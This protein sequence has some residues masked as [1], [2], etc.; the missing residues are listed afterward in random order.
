VRAELGCGP[1]DFLLALVFALL[2]GLFCEVIYDGASS[3]HAADGGRL[4][5]ALADPQHVAIDGVYGAFVRESMDGGGLFVHN[6]Q[7]TEPHA[8]AMFRPWEYLVGKLA[9]RTPGAAANPAGAAFHTERRLAVLLFALGIAWLGAE[10][11]RSFWL[12]AFALWAAM[13]GGNLFG[14]VEWLGRDSAVGSY[15]RTWIDTGAPDLSGLGFAYPALL[16]GTPHLALE[17]A[18]FAGAMG[19]TL[20]C[21]RLL[22]GPHS[23]ARLA[24]AVVCGS[25]CLFFLAAVRPYTAPVAV[26]AICAALGPLIFTGAKT[27]EAQE[28]LPT[29]RLRAFLALALIGLPTLPLLLHLRSL[30]AGDS[31]FSGLDVV[32]LSP[33]LVEQLL[34]YGPA[35]LVLLALLPSLVSKRSSPAKWSPAARLL[36]TWL[37]ANLALGNASPLVNW[38]VEALLPISLA[39]LMLTLFTLQGRPQMRV[40]LGFILLVGLSSSLQRL[41]ELDERLAAGD[42]ALWLSPEDAGVVDFLGANRLGTLD[43]D[44]SPGALVYKPSLARLIPW[45]AGTRVFTGH[46]DHTPDYARKADFEGRFRLNGQ[47][48]RLLVEGGVAF[49]VTP[50]R[51]PA[52]NDPLDGHASLERAWVVGNLRVDRLRMPKNQPKTGTPPGE[53]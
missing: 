21:S 36:S 52:Q 15:L 22:Q 1:R 53:D 9:A 49:V 35:I 17:I 40:A 43:E 3:K 28:Q 38:E 12:R 24:L 16:L 5:G 51:D 39:V 50:G 2:F 25:T 32:H 14:I 23:R 29:S 33:P 34:F 4:V 41:T 18:F 26:L 44:R 27:K 6:H 10:L 31:V 8:A 19:A 13:L 37:L 42:T 11:L 48:A 47:G 7:T 30:I 20:T 46:P 45:L